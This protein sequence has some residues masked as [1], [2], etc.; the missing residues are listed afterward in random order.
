MKEVIPVLIETILGFVV[1]EL[2]YL[3]IHLELV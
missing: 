3:V 1:Q 2:E